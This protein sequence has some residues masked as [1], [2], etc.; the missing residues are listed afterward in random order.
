MKFCTRREWLLLMGWLLLSRLV[1][2]VFMPLMDPSEARYSVITQNMVISGNY[3]EPQFIYNGVFQNYEGKPAFVFQL[4]ALSC[5]IFGVDPFAVRF[6]ALMAGVFIV[7]LVYWAVRCLRD[8][9]TARM[10]SLLC[11]VSFVFYLYSGLMMIDLVLA[12]CVT[13]AILAYVFFSAEPQPGRRKKAFSVAYFAALGV[14]MVVKGPVALV[15]AGFP[16]FLFVLINGRWKELRHHAWI[17]GTLVFLLVSV[18]WYLLMTLKNPDFLEYFFL[19][20][21]FGR[22][23]YQNYGDRYGVGCE[24]F[25][26]MAVLWFLL[27]NLPLLF[28]LPLIKPF[29]QKF[30]AGKI[31]SD[32]LT[33]LS[34]LTVLGITFFWSLTSRSLL[35]YLL[36]TIPFTAV[37]IAVRHADGGLLE[38]SKLVS[39][40]RWGVRLFAILLPILMTA[41]VWYGVNYTDKMPARMYKNEKIQYLGP[42]CVYFAC[43]TPYSADFYLKD[44]VV[45][46]S[47]ESM[48]QSLEKSSGK[49]LCVSDPQREKYGK[50]IPRKLWFRSGCW[51]VY[52]PEN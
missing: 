52:E 13:A 5:K 33:G 19:H 25:H 24:T 43:V 9:Q 27:A 42:Q 22:F 28:F 4:G 37:F 2:N 17:I 30:F 41:A 50:E 35:Y 8:V 34:L 21:N 6:P 3:L 38:N 14:G 16:V 46:H 10:A 26:V 47:W 18:P 45:I 39:K 48:D 51:S 29:R 11:A 12:S 23:L 31:F 7:G 36:S 40:L 1:L 15:M 49:F 20:E 32:P 44:R